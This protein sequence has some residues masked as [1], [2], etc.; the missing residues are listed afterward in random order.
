MDVGADLVM[1]V[2]T[3]W[4][5]AR[6]STVAHVAL[7][8]S[9]RV[10]VVLPPVLTPGELS[11][12]HR[13]VRAGDVSCRRLGAV[14]DRGC[15]ARLRGALRAAVEVRSNWTGGASA[16]GEGASVSVIAARS[17]ART[18]GELAHG[19]VVEASQPIAR[20]LVWC[21]IEAVRAEQCDRVLEA[22]LALR[23][24]ANWEGRSRS[25][26]DPA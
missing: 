20:E 2:P 7:V 25:S 21:G 24:L 19:G 8:A 10:D 17:L 1:T 5:Y 6:V 22:V 9:S 12:F 23:E 26:A 4:G 18:I 15:A 16:K 13:R 3:V 11:V 14:V